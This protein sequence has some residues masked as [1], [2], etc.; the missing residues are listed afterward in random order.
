MRLLMALDRNK[1]TRLLR[2]IERQGFD[3]DFR[4]FSLVGKKGARDYRFSL[5]PLID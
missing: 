1:A 5:Q 3:L 2:H 4:A